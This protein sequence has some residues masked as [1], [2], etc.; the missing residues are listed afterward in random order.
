MK[1]V[2]YQEGVMNLSFRLA[3]ALLVLVVGGLLACSNAI[4]P[5]E[6]RG[7]EV[8]NGVDDDCD[9]ATDEGFDVGASCDG[10]DADSCANG[11]ATC[12]ADGSGV[13]CVNED[14]VDIAEICN[15]AD[16]DCDGETDEGLSLCRCTGGQ[17]PVA[18]ICNQ[19]DDDCNGS[20]DDGLS[21]CGCT[22][23]NPPGT[24]T[25]NGIDDDCDEAIDEGFGVGLP[26]D[27]DDD[28]LCANGITA[29]TPD[30]TGVEC[31]DEDPV[32]L[33][34]VCNNQD[35]DCDTQ[36]DEGLVDC[37]CTGGN[38]PGTETCNGIDDDC[39][40]LIDDGFALG[41][42]CDGPDGDQCANGVSTCT[43][44][45]TGVECINE[46]PTDIAETCNN[47][48][49]D[50]DN[51]ID[52]G[53]ADCQCAGGSP[54]GT[55]VCDG[56]DNDCD[57]AIDEDNGSGGGCA[58][59]GDPCNGYLDCVSQ[60]CA[61]DL[62]ERYCSE[63]CD[64]LSDPGTWPAGY[65][66]IVGGNRDYFVRDYPP[67]GSNADCAPDQVCTVQDANDLLSVV[68][69]CRPPLDPGA[70]PG[71]D[72]ASDQCANGMC[73]WRI[74]LCTEV[75]TVAGDCALQYLDHD[76]TCVLSGHL[77]RPGVCSRDEQCPAAYTCQDG[78]CLGPAC[79]DDLD[80]ETGYA[81]LPPAQTPPDLVCQSQPFYDYIGECIIGCDGDPDCP[82]GL[83]CHPSVAVDQL[84]I[85]GNCRN[86]YTG[87]TVPTDSGPCGVG[88]DPCSH[89]I[90]YSAGGGVTYCTQLC[91]D[92]LDCPGTMECT[93]GTLHMGELGSF[94]NTMTCTRP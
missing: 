83:Q 12:T 9:G 94:P 66:C 35:D 60:I 3:C 50:C 54:P 67:C 1:Q 72:C 7:D 25:C 39:N 8:C 69:E 89:G 93:S 24:E 36:I 32:N 40:Q 51:V 77:V 61:G 84:S 90:C 85:Q 28:D 48:D 65:L 41:Q 75:C 22:G 59:F 53:L 80:C 78:S 26:C 31:A 43:P 62:F 91:G 18:E 16:D 34:E 17:D 45:G 33:T 81:C 52:N 88:Y 20:A 6:P 29:C 38:P 49:D 19:I 76:T 68:T 58:G 2:S 44:D 87:D 30:G 70:E 47:E 14:P 10:V 37:G 63:E 57:E 15:H 4:A 56:V 55:E 79:V 86:P 21:T 73:S 82:A 74:D 71:Q 46:D 13:E 23:G 42:A 11:T 5:C 27:G 92:T 64:P